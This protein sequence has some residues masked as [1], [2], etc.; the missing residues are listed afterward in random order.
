MGIECF[1]RI[2]ERICRQIMNDSHIFKNGYRVA[3]DVTPAVV[4]SLR[5]SNNKIM[6]ETSLRYILRDCDE[7]IKLI[8]TM[9]GIKP[10]E[11]CVLFDN[12]S[13]RAKIPTQKKR[14]LER[15]SVINRMKSI[16]YQE[17]LKLIQL[18][19]KPKMET[20]QES[21]ETNQESLERNQHLLEKN[22]HSLDTKSLETNQDSL[23]TNSLETNQDSLDTKSLET[24]QDSLQKN[25]MEIKQ[26]SIAESHDQQ[27]NHLLEP[28]NDLDENNRKIDEPLDSKLD[29]TAS[30]ELVAVMYDVTTLKISD[31]RDIVERVVLTTMNVYVENNDGLIYNEEE[32]EAEMKC[33]RLN[34]WSDC[35]LPTVLVFNDNDLYIY[36]LSK[37]MSFEKDLF[38]VFDQVTGRLYS[39][40]DGILST[41]RYLRDEFR[42]HSWTLLL[43][44]SICFG[45]DYC[46]GIISRNS[47]HRLYVF[48]SMITYLHTHKSSM[49]TIDKNNLNVPEIIAL[50]ILQLRECLL[51]FCSRSFVR[52]TPA[53]EINKTT[54]NSRK[55]WWLDDYTKKRLDRNISNTQ[56]ESFISNDKDL[57]TMIPTLNLS[58]APAFLNDKQEPQ[59]PPLVI[60]YDDD[61]FI[62]P[63]VW[64]RRHYWHLLYA[65]E[66][67]LKFL[68]GE[69]YENSPMFMI[70]RYMSSAHLSLEAFFNLNARDWYAIMKRMLPS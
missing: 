58:I 59:K 37:Q 46:E 53:V 5:L 15:T 47:T 67:P 20:N 54:N 68:K 13:P 45:N 33:F 70:N 55:C 22:Q 63:Y 16:T 6:F 32:G 18:E 2:R 26:Q 44:M 61:K 25:Q 43:W 49:V 64:F 60:A 27:S 1:S 40:W 69:H 38:V 66:M 4:K 21:L 31:V 28:I 11:M 17:K 12:R 51:D 23:D 30:S 34:C 62:V 24:N 50:A 36:L 29:D 52:H 65:T 56:H 14:L 7:I 42:S 48:D 10:K 41:H 39:C 19:S 3:Y 8:H 35:V 57:I 9:G